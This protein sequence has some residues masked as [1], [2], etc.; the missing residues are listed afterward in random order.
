MVNADA[1]LVVAVLER[2]I[3]KS[4]LILKNRDLNYSNLTNTK[5]VSFSE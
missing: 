3:P 1:R 2:P 5:K 4:L